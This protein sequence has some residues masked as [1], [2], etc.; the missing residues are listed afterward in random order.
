MYILTI[1]LVWILGYGNDLQVATTLGA[2]AV[3]GIILPLV[4]SLWGL[5]AHFILRKLKINYV[6]WYAVL[7]SLPGA[8]FVTIFTPFGND[9]L[10]AVVGQSMFCSFIGATGAVVFWAFAA[11]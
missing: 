6:L 7:G 9:S 4:F 10:S 11:K 1:A 5:L 3:A 8:L 2:A